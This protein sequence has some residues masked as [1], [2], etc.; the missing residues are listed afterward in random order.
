MKFNESHLEF[1]DTKLGAFSVVTERENFDSQITV[2]REEKEIILNYFGSESIH[3]GN[4][5]SDP[6]GSLKEF[7]L[8]P[9]MDPIKLNLVYPK[10]EKSELRLYLSKESGF[11]PSGTDIWFTYINNEDKLVIGSYPQHIWLEVGSEIN[12]HSF[13][14]GAMS[15]IQMGEELIG[16]PS[17][18]INEL[19]KNSYD[20]DATSCK[21]YFNVDK[22][23]NDNSFALIYDNGSGM[24]DT[25]LF[26]DW[27]KPSISS[28]RKEK[29]KS[30]L[31]D[32][33]LLGK[34]GIGRLAAMALGESVTVISRMEKSQPYNWI[35]VNRALFRDDRL[36][37]EVKFPG[38]K[39]DSFTSL[40]YE[41]FYYNQ[42]TGLKNKSLI[43]VL[44]KNNLQ[45]FK[46][47]TLI[48]IERLDNSVIKQLYEDFAQKTLF[49]E[50]KNQF[51]NAS[52]YKSLSTLITPFKIGNEI[53]N[54]LTEKKIVNGVSLDLSKENLF[55]I[56]FSTNLI[57]KTNFPTIDWISV[58][59]LSIQKTFDYRLYGKV[60]RNGN[61]QA[62]YSVRR[63]ENR[64]IDETI[65][66]TRGEIFDE[67]LSG[68]KEEPNLFTSTSDNDA[69]EYYFDIRVYD[70]GEKDNL[71]KLA[72]QSKFDTGSK[73]KSAFKN[74][75]G[76]RVSKNGFGV[77]PYGEEVEDWIGLS[78]ERVQNPGQNISTNQIIGYVY[79]FSPEND[80]LEEKTNRE[81]FIEN[82]AFNQVKTTI[83]AIFKDLGRRR[84]N[85][86]LANGLGRI[87][88]SKHKRPDFDEFLNKLKSSQYADE[89]FINY[90]E[91][92]MK[93]VNTSMDNLEESLSFAER[94]ASL[95]SGI[96]LV[97]HEMA[98][99]I[100]GL[101]IT[102]S[103]LSMITNKIE[104]SEL[105]L[106]IEDINSLTHSTDVLAELRE[107][108]QP[109][110]GRSRK[111]LF[112]PYTTFM[113]VVNL[114]KSDIEDLDIK[115]SVDDRLMN[116]II[117]DFEYAFWISFLNII[118]N[119]IYWIKKTQMRCEIR[120]YLS[121]DK[122]II[123]NNGPRIREDI[124]DH[125][126]K[127]G[128][129]AR[130]EKNATGLGLAF[131]QSILSRND[132]EI[133][134]ENSDF[135]PTF[136][137]YKSIENE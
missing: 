7:L 82:T 33:N 117:D 87:P 54:E 118:N 69:G 123:S 66:I 131:T 21:V 23:N 112:S 45:N 67:S 91:R 104:P 106:F 89:R 135:G 28:K 42:R 110:I 97:Y 85:F 17:T 19:V 101:R 70:I 129:T 75:Q 102:K 13:E 11:K 49:I 99:P 84:Y 76:L 40:F 90:S 115:V 14:P 137:I 53:Y 18:A 130:I 60:D 128:V 86:R 124:I 108:L 72:Q 59:S 35:T 74:L 5:S 120:F 73:F 125:I 56:Y 9:E 126:F 113:K 8:Y 36:L 94:L 111:K 83:S 100:S 2:T 10:P 30:E 32:R 116:Y 31:Y 61:V 92:F 103:S 98:Q 27:L 65:E 12:Q 48:I 57:P 1:F 3:R 95:G 136:T 44:K 47:G 105:D 26:G 22:E 37:S 62:Y 122:I 39:V 77:K 81:G 63:I 29:A 88:D 43:E 52:F 68:N 127:Y 133:S 134:A 58:E 119:A 71:E 6:I 132:W 25:L 20:A 80:A 38:D 107:S 79:F 55:N 93:E 50:D 64:F 46:K 114:F 34:K 51:I 15:I 4:K 16:H 78:K 41:K 109:A 121:G 24:D 96:E